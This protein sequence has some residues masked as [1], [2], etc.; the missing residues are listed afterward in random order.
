MGQGLY[1]EIEQG[2]AMSG[3]MSASGGQ[4]KLLCSRDLE[5]RPPWQLAAW[6]S[7]G[8]TP[9][10]NVMKRWCPTAGADLKQRMVVEFGTRGGPSLTAWYADQA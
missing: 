5:Q 7:R 3:T 10:A 6:V 4:G 8:T 9:M 2:Q 1:W